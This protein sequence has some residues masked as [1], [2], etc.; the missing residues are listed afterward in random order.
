VYVWKD[1][2]E[3]TPIKNY[4]NSTLFELSNSADDSEQ[5]EFVSHTNPP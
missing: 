2:S 3:P 4:N 1:E 5:F